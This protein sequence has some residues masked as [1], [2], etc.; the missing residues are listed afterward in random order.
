LEGDWDEEGGTDEYTKEEL[1]KLQFEKG[2][3]TVEIT[4]DEPITYWWRYLIIMIMWAMGIVFLVSVD[5]TTVEIHK[6]HKIMILANTN[7]W[8]FCRRK[9]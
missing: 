8:L 6:E 4:P 1:H 2:L 9:S 5:Y 3:P 7:P